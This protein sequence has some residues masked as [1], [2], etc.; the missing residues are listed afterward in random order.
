MA[1]T[2]IPTLVR[3]LLNSS[4]SMVSVSLG[5]FDVDRQCSGFFSTLRQTSVQTLIRRMYLDCCMTNT[6]AVTIKGL[7]AAGRGN[8]VV[9]WA[10]YA[11]SGNGAFTT[12][13]KMR[14]TVGEDL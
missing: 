12:Y 11:V 1:L 3:K 14:C 4:I 8:G 7:T 6:S 9:A 5:F 2:H 13:P 10:R